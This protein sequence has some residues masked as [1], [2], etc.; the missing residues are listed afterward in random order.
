MGGRGGGAFSLPLDTMRR[1]GNST[2]QGWGG[3]QQPSRWIRSLSTESIE[4]FSNPRESSRNT[5][6]DYAAFIGAPVCTRRSAFAFHSSA[7]RCVC[8]RVSLGGVFYTPLT[9]T[10]C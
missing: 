4:Y 7:L 2:L 1:K 9:A 8:V 10:A 6:L 3:G 5:C